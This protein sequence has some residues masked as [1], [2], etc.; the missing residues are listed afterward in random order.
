MDECVRIGSRCRNPRR[1]DESDVDLAEYALA[2]PV[3]VVPHDRARE[4]AAVARIE[5]IALD[6]E[7][8]ERAGRRLGER[9]VRRKPRF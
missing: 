6:E 9:R 5:R 8:L 4:C 3:R 2:D 7:M 1:G